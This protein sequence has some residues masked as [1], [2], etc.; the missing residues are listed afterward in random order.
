SGTC[1]Y[2]YLKESSKFADIIFMPYNY[3]IDPYIR[4]SLE[5]NLKN[6][7]LIIDEAHN[8]DSVSS[9]SCSFDI[10]TYELTSAVTE[11]NELLD[12]FEFSSSSSIDISQNIIQDDI[13]LLLLF[14]SNLA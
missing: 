7:I 4:K 9:E 5:I 12:A 1:T 2:F 10:S 14:A 13:N 8:L 11:I 6:S 3:V